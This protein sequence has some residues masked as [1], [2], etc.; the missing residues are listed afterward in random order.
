MIT[1]ASLVLGTHGRDAA[2]LRSLTVSW[3]GGVCMGGVR[4]LGVSVPAMGD[5]DGGVMKEIGLKA[6]AFMPLGFT[7][8]GNQGAAGNRDVRRHRR[9]ISH[10][11]HMVHSRHHVAK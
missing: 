5:C 10:W 6:G 4:L 3:L 11:V 1:Q 7:L 2:Y 9:S 8:Q